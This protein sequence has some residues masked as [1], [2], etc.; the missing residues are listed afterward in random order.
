MQPSVREI[1]FLNS[2]LPN[3]LRMG[4]NENSKIYVAGHRGLVG[5]AI[6]RELQKQGFKNLVGKNLGVMGLSKK[7]QG[8]QDIFARVTA[9]E[10][11]K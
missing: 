4:M 5:S 6:W 2:N 10:R 7:E 8:I 11:K 9:E 1:F 3:T